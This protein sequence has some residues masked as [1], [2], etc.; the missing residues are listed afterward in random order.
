MIYMNK[1]AFTLAEV[2]ITLS[3]VGVVAAMTL[4]T[5]LNNVADKELNAKFS[6]SK[7]IL[8][9]GYKL[10][11]AK[12]ETFRVGDLP[13]MNSCNN[14]ND[15]SC[16]SKAHKAI[17]NI[18]KDSNSGLTASMLQDLYA[19]ENNDQASPF[20]WSD[21]KYIYQTNDGMTFGVIPGEEY[22]SF[23]I[24]V[25]L[26]GKKNPNIA[27]KDLRKLRFSGNGGNLYDVSEEL[28]I[29]SNCSADNLSGCTT[30]EQ[31]YSLDLSSDMASAGYYLS[32]DGSQCNIYYGN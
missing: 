21:V 12:S 9:N 19:I 20:R 3:I 13:F 23:D 24:V 18:V 10:M 11:M 6:K 2:L 14:L 15:T 1:N 30:E 31:C 32:W 26:N 29:V 4:P 22:T 17:F 8:A 27:M 5:V 7:S 25:D 16:V 28:T